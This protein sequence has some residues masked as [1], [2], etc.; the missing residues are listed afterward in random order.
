MNVRLTKIIG[1]SLILTIFVILWLTLPGGT[2]EAQ[3]S[4]GN[5]PI[6]WQW[7]ETDPETDITICA[8]YRESPASG[9]AK[10]RKHRLDHPM[11]TLIEQPYPPTPTCKKEKK[12]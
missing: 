6:W 12:K 10:G 11:F 3:E 8:W 4:H 9:N 1:V 5:S 7:C 2:A